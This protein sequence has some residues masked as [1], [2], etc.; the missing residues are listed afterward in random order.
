[1]TGG[2]REHALVGRAIEEPRRSSPCVSAA[3]AQTPFRNAARMFGCQSLSV[4]RH[5][6]GRAPSIWRRFQTRRP[7][8][9]RRQ[10]EA[11]HAGFVEAARGVIPMTLNP[12]SRRTSSSR[13]CV[14]SVTKT[15]RRSGRPRASGEPNNRSTVSEAVA[16]PD[17][18][19]RIVCGGANAGNRVRYAVGVL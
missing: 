16:L 18:A 15:T 1:M 10:R 6:A 17:A 7:K 2:Q 4:N 3:T 9:R 13:K 11:H 14:P 5:S 19:R 8:Q 12:C